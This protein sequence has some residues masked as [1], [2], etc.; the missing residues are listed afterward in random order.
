MAAPEP[1]D[2]ASAS[3]RTTP[4]NPRQVCRPVL[5][6][7]LTRSTC[8][9]HQKMVPSTSATARKDP[10]VKLTLRHILQ[11]LAGSPCPC[12]SSTNFSSGLT[13]RPSNWQIQHCNHRAQKM[14]HIL[15]PGSH[16]PCHGPC[17]TTPSSELTSRPASL[18]SHHCNCMGLQASV[19]RWAALVARRWAAALVAR[20]WASAVA[21]SAGTHGDESDSTTPSYPLS[22]CSPPM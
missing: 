21:P 2:G 22:T 16:T 5:F 8:Q 12:L 14:S 10:I 1:E 9:Q 15:R 3:T 4:C 20:R 19:A 13:S 18:Q 17:S 11:L 6:R 7:L